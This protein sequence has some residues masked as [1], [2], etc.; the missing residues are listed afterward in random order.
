MTI[1]TD[2]FCPSNDVEAH[3]S[4]YASLFETDG[5][6]ETISAILQDLSEVPTAGR[7]AFVLGSVP[8]GVLGHANAKVLRDLLPSAE[9]VGLAVKH[10]RA[11]NADRPLLEEAARVVGELE[12]GTNPRKEFWNLAF[13]YVEFEGFLWDYAPIGI[14]K[15]VPRPRGTPRIHE[16]IAFPEATFLRERRSPVKVWEDFDWRQELDQYPLHQVLSR[17]EAAARR[18]RNGYE[19]SRCVR[20]LPTEL[21]LHKDGGYLRNMLLGGDTFDVYRTSALQPEL[22]EAQLNELVS[23]IANMNRE[24][25]VT[26]WLE[27][28]EHSPHKALLEERTPE[29]IEIELIRRRHAPFLKTLELIAPYDRPACTA[30]AAVELYPELGD[31]D[32]NLAARWAGRDASDYEMAKML[33]A[34]AA[35]RAAARFYEDLGFAVEDVAIRQVI[36]P[37]DTNWRTHDLLVEGHGP[38]DVKNARTSTNSG[39]SYSEH[40]IPQFKENRNRQDVIV[41]GVRSP[42]LKLGELTD[43][44]NVPY[45]RDVPILVLGECTRQ[46]L[47]DLRQQFLSASLH[48]INLSRQGFK[49]MLPPWVFN[50]PARFYEQEEIRTYRTAIARVLE[51][52]PPAWPALKRLS[53]N[54]LP[55]YLQQGSLPEVWRA[56]LNGWE[57]QLAERIIAQA[58][59]SLPDL[60]LTLLTDF[61]EAIQEERAGFDPSRYRQF[62]YP[63]TALRDEMAWHHLPLGIFDPLESIKS[64]IQ[65]L[66]LLWQ[67]RALSRLS[68]FTRFQFIGAG[69]LRG[70]REDDTTRTTLLAYCGGYTPKHG[71]CGNTPLILGREEACRACGYLICKMCGHCSG[72]CQE[73][74]LR[75][76]NMEGQ[77]RPA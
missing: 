42:Y 11:G 29:K 50:Y 48:D 15:I 75:Q 35:E 1:S 24:Q 63:R 13:K 68:E 59:T 54:P 20:T 58:R 72:G 69:L 45:H 73:R 46:Q 74:L 65:T 61:L 41:L 36:Y 19:R 8:D 4:R 2:G 56:E 16:T 38:V 30:R 55:L 5:V 3:H 66:E 28:L 49:E 51:H 22:T 7:P 32:R 67:N 47:A 62:I 10:M 43:P 71:P 77:R 17:A 18:I 39:G 52:D 33:S 12:A 31:D 70:M 37:A 57:T 53:L 25:A 23:A 64:L 6:T 34:R 27:I 9:R 44:A 26:L 21:L 14:R 60:F 40:T 76:E